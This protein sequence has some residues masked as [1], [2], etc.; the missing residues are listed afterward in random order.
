ML[1]LFSSAVM[2][3]KMFVYIFSCDVAAA[4]VNTEMNNYFQWTQNNYAHRRVKEQNNYAR[5]RVKI[6]MVAMCLCMHTLH[7][8]RP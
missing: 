7:V 6:C 8:F 2:A 1:Q 5:R 4:E 3:L